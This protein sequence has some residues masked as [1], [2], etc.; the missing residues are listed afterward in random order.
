MDRH[1]GQQLV[2][3]VSTIEFS[4]GQNTMMQSITLPQSDWQKYQLTTTWLLIMA[5]ASILAIVG[6]LYI[7]VDLLG[8]HLVW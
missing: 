4:R 5:T 6:F 8:A 1:A 3:Y 2:A 7:L